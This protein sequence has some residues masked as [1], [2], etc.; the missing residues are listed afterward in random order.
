MTL[1]ALRHLGCSTFESATTGC[2]LGG[3][4]VAIDEDSAAD[5]GLAE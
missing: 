3:V 4:Q 2:V 1:D 5:V